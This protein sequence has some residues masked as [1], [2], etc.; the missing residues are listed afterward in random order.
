MLIATDKSRCSG[1]KA[2]AN[3]CPVNAISFQY[4]E[5]GFFYPII[6]AETCINCRLCEKVC[7]YNDVNH[8]V[9]AVNESE[10]PVFYAAQLKNISELGSVSSGGAFQALAQSVIERDGIVYGAAQVDVDH[11]FH[12]RATNM[13]ELKQTRRS[14]YFQSDI[15][16]C[17]KE[18]LNDLKAGKIVLFS[19][20]GCQVA[21]L[22]T[23]LHKRYDNL[24]TCEVVC[25]GVPSRK[26]WEA[27]RKE[28]EL[29]EGKK[30]KDLVFRDKSLGWSNNQYKIIYDDGSI[31]YEKSAQQLF[32][33]G[34]LKGLFYRP[35]CGSCPFAS[36][37][38]VADI[39]LADFWKYSGKMRDGDMGISLI[40]I[41]NSHGND[42]LTLSSEFLYIEPTTSEIALYSCKHM[43]GH[44]EENKFR[45]AFLKKTFSDGYYSAARR[46]IERESIICRVER[47]VKSFLRR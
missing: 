32:H 5:E 3:A 47:K 18:V 14:K 12:I 26:V 16:M 40:G 20:T 22:N 35:S 27:Y 46:Y 33:L 4:D 30:I 25:H 38:R 36:M 11:I 31:E 39:S 19:G 24:Y 43:H 44:P 9:P 8:G 15:G 21:G 13:N 37:P 7:P 42:L 41:N 17:Y 2:C 29:R 1:C 10:L 23:F 34:Y 6:D 45:K 28:K